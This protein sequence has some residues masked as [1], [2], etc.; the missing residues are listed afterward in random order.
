MQPF[1]GRLAEFAAAHTGE[2]LID[3]RA[4][5]FDNWLPSF[6]ALLDTGNGLLFRF[7]VSKGITRPDLGDFRSGG[8]IGDNTGVLRNEG[9]LETGPLFALATGNRNL[10]PISSWNYDLSVEWYF[11]RVGSLTLTA[12]SRT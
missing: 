8:T 1:A 5:V 7:A 11:D 10:R 12:S 2:I 6:N 9:T 3:D 4:V